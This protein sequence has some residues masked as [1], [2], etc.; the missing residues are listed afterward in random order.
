MKII[1]QDDSKLI[2][3]EKPPISSILITILFTILPLTFV[4]AM[5]YDIGVTNLKCK[6]LEPTQVNCEIQQ[7]KF[8]GFVE[9]PPKAFSKVTSAKLKTLREIGSEGE[10]LV[11]NLVVLNTNQGE[12]T[13]IEDSVFFNGVRGDASQMQSIANQINKFLD[14]NQVSLQIQ[15]DLRGNFGQSIFPLIFISLFVLGGVILLFVILRS[16]TLVFDKKSGQLIREQKTLLGKK[17]EYYPLDEIKGVDIEEKYN[18]KKGISYELKLIS[19]NIHRKILISDKNLR[20]VKNL[21]IT[22]YEFLP[23]PLPKTFPYFF[24]RALFLQKLITEENAKTLRFAVVYAVSIKILP[25]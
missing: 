2:L 8:F 22:I 17:Y 23:I 1:Q 7:S 16:Q 5:I 11:S 20:Y 25:Q 3:K 21:R 24:L 12:I 9:Q 19:K 15:R 14:S 4:L 10:P 6:R 18:S 13:V